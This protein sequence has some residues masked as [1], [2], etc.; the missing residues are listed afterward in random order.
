MSD[1]F[2]GY[3]DLGKTVFSCAGCGKE[4]ATIWRVDPKVTKTVKAKVDCPFCSDSSIVDEIP[5]EFFVGIP[6]GV[7]NISHIEP[8]E[9]MDADVLLFTAVKK[10]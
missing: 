7:T 5:E 6:E 8:P 2:K 1:E 10:E 3:E 4:L 9:D